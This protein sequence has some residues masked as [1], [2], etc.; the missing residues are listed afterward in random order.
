MLALVHGIALLAL[1]MPDF[2]LAIVGCCRCP[3][4]RVPC[5][6]FEANRRSCRSR[7]SDSLL[8]TSQ[9]EPMYFQRPEQLLEIFT[10]LEVRSL[11]PLCIRVPGLHVVFDAL[12][13]SVSPVRLVLCSIEDGRLSTGC[14]LLCALCWSVRSQQLLVC[15]AATCS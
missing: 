13:C 11:V 10:Q 5:A 9:D 8:F 2:G 4:Q 7:G 14:T 3:A 6:P 15:R 12:T 1:L